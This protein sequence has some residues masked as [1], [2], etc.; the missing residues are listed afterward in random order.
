MLN[1]QS[2]FFVELIISKPC[3][4]MLNVRLRKVLRNPTL[5]LVKSSLKGRGNTGPKLLYALRSVCWNCFDTHMKLSWVC[6]F[7]WVFKSVCQMVSDLQ[8]FHQNSFCVVAAKTKLNSWKSQQ[9][10]LAETI[11]QMFLQVRNCRVIREWIVIDRF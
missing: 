9:W 6:W 11:N 1:G 4:V 7:S 5:Q 2:Q 3:L 8:M 10:K